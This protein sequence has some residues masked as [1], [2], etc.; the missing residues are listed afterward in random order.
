MSARSLLDARTADIDGIP[1][2]AMDAR[3][4]PPGAR[5]SLAVLRATAADVLVRH[6]GRGG[7]CT[8]CGSAWP[9]DL[10]RRAECHV[11]GW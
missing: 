1:S 5:F 10:V 4:Y 3:A 11:S 2:A 7:A 8:A 9:C 6:T